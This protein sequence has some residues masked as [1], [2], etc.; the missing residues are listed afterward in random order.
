MRE[1]FGFKKSILVAHCF[2]VSR[3]KI[4]KTAK[5]FP[6]LF[7]QRIQGKRCAK[8]FIENFS[9]LFCQKIKPIFW[10]NRLIEASSGAGQGCRL[11]AGGYA[12][13]TPHCFSRLYF[14]GSDIL[15]KN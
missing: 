14:S 15:F 8:F 10:L 9:T 2:K 4:V 7:I 5:A 3:R 6:A 1:F 11:N 12:G 13:S